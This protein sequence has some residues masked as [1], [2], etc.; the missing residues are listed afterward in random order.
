M[1]TAYTAA[2]NSRCIKRKVGAVIIDEKNDIVLSTGYNEAPKPAEACTLKYAGRCYRDIYKQN[3]FRELEE[4]GQKCPKCEKK[5]EDTVY[6]FHCKKCD[7]DFDKHFIRDKALNRCRALHAE[8]KAI[9]GLGTR[10]TEGL[11]L[12]TTTFPCFSCAK[13]IVYGKFEN[14]IYVEPYPD[15][16]SIEVLRDVG[17]A[18]NKFEGVKARAYFRL[19][20]GQ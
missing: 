20:G 15:E 4:R 17:V 11:T 5:L 18:V 6:P 13:K 1:N 19:F 14:V 9:L 3:Y 10:N 12:Y 8:E 7:F 16:E 2:A